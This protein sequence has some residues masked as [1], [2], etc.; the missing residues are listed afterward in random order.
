MQGL[1]G[2]CSQSL[3]L[4]YSAR[5]RILGEIA[6]RFSA[7]H[8]ALRHV[9]L[10]PLPAPPAQD[11]SFVLGAQATPRSAPRAI[12]ASLECRRA[13]LPGGHGAEPETAGA[14]PGAARGL[15]TQH[16]LKST[17]ERKPS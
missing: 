5:R 16:R 17:G 7:S 2:H 14:V 4:T 8:I 9:S 6:I 13:V 1:M 11:R 15:G 12:A 3:K 10:Y